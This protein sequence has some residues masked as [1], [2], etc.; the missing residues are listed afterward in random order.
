MFEIS[1]LSSQSVSQMLQSSS[2]PGKLLSPP[3]TIFC[4]QVLQLRS[5]FPSNDS[6]QAYHKDVSQDIRRCQ[7]QRG[8]STTFQVKPEELSQLLEESSSRGFDASYELTKMSIIRMSFVKGSPSPLF[9]IS[10]ISL[11]GWGAEYQR[12]DVTSTP[13]WIE[14]HLHAPLTV[15]LSLSSNPTHPF[16]WLDRVLSSMS[17]S[18]RAI[19]SMS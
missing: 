6:L 11:L 2:N 1:V 19:S 8:I 12:Q 4:S 10:S 13:C 17:P 9:S 16:Q 14:I 3:S 7:V 15:T 18:T 5:M